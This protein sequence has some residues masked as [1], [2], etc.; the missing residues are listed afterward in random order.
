MQAVYVLPETDT[1]RVVAELFEHVLARE[2]IGRDDDFFMQG[3]GSLQA[4]MLLARL[5]KTF[6]VELS[7]RV[8]FEERTVQRLAGAVDK[9]LEDP[10]SAAK[11]SGTVAQ[12]LAELDAETSVAELSL[13]P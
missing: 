13:E 4:L 8:L 3:G 7:L 9:L 6:Q 12:A 2:R 10:R 5:R 1:E 11:L